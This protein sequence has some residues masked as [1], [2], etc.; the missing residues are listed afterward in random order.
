MSKNSINREGA[1]LKAIGKH[2]NKNINL[3][4]YADPT[5]QPGEF[6]ID[7][8][9]G[10]VSATMEEITTAI[11]ALMDRITATESDKSGDDGAKKQ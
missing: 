3:D 6:K 1:D 5:L 4:F 2:L 8:D 11:D 9:H 10:G 7:W